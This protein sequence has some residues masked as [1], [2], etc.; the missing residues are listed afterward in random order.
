LS[1]LAQSLRPQH[2]VWPTGLTYLSLPSP[3]QSESP[4]ASCDDAGDAEIN[5]AIANTVEPNTETHRRDEPHLD[6]LIRINR[7][8]SELIFAFQHCQPAAVLRAGFLVNAGAFGT[9][10]CTELQVVAR[11]RPIIATSVIQIVKTV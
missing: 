10:C 3:I 8:S 9:L 5:V 2:R 6:V 11:R 1:I 4:S 7:S